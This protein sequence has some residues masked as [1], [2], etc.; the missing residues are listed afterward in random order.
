MQKRLEDVSQIQFVLKEI[1]TNFENHLKS[2]L[3]LKHFIFEVHQ[4]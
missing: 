4:L 2:Q 1:F 3:K